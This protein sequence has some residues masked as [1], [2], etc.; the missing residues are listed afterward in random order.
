MPKRHLITSATFREAPAEDVVV[1][2]FATSMEKND[3]EVRFVISDGSVDREN[4]TVSPKGWDLDSFKNNPVVLWAHNHR[5]LPVGVATS[6]KE[7]GGKLLASMKFAEHEFAQTVKQMVEG[8]FLRTVSVGFRPLEWT[9]NE[10]RGGIDFK[11]QELLEFSVVPV[12]ANPNALIAA[13]AKGIDLTPLKGWITE[14]IKSWPG[15][16]G[17]VVKVVTAEPEVRSDEPGDVEV[18][19]REIEASADNGQ[20]TLIE[21]NGEVF[22]VGTDEDGEPYIE[23]VAKAEE[24]TPQGVSVVREVGDTRITYTA[25]T[26]A[27]VRELIAADESAIPADNGTP[28]PFFTLLD[29]APETVSFDA[30]ELRDSLASA[31]KQR[32][33]EA[34]TRE[35]IRYARGA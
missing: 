24:V 31:V 28:E 3:D 14:T 32:C 25:P 5:E 6:V 16:F 18:D 12:P 22:A 33:V 15:E 19:V 7:Q 35:A 29:N 23:R 9:I 13:S 2:K 20:D 8:G 34:H 11:R 10:E 26:A 4:D 17:P 1:Q 27:E 30:E 21:R